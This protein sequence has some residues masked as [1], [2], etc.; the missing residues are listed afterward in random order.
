MRLT[1][2]SDYALRTL[3]YVAT[4]PGRTVPISEMARYYEISQNHLAKVV[5]ELVRTGLLKST[6][7]R[8]GG[9]QLALPPSEIRLGQT[10]C[11]TEPDMKLIDCVGC[12]I[13]P[14]CGLPAMLGEAMAAFVATLDSYTLA[15][16]AQ[17]SGPVSAAGA[18]AAGNRP[19][20]D[21]DQIKRRQSPVATTSA[22][23][24]GEDVHCV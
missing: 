24:A 21:I 22:G 14:V 8:V 10:I 19:K 2:Y 4:N 12:V 7:G 13:A 15:D 16:L 20:I 6:R 5:N 17:R 18:I 9:V 11:S 3:L 23:T 1:R